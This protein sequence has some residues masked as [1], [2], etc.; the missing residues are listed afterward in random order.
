MLKLDVITHKYRAGGNFLGRQVSD[1][2]TK[3]DGG[4]KSP[5]GWFGGGRCGDPQGEDKGDSWEEDF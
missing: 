4:R 1:C 3:A 5:P 2:G